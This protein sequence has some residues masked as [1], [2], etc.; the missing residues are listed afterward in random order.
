MVRHYQCTIGTKASR[1]FV[2][3]A[4]TYREAAVKAVN[5]LR[6]KQPAGWALRINGKVGRPGTFQAIRYEGYTPRPLGPKI[7]IQEV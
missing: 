5:A 3:E 7:R 6:P 2:V 1:Y 4:P